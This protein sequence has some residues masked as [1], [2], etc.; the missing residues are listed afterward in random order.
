MESL[1]AVGTPVLGVVINGCELRQNEYNYWQGAYGGDG[2]ALTAEVAI[3][4][5]SAESSIDGQES[6]VSGSRDSEA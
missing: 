4:P 5:S 2:L 1:Q 3:A 6:N